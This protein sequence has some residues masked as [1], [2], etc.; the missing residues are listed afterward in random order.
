MLPIAEQHF[1]RLN[2]PERLAK[3]ADG[4]TYVSGSE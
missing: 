4:A 1:H 3:V 2:A